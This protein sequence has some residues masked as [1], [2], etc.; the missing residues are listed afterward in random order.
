MHSHGTSPHEVDPIGVVLTFCAAHDGD[1]VLPLD[2]AVRLALECSEVRRPDAQ[3]VTAVAAAFLD[4]GTVSSHDPS[5]N[6]VTIIPAIFRGFS[7]PVRPTAEEIR[8]GCLVVGDRLAPYVAPSVTIDSLDLRTA[9]GDPVGRKRVEL[10]WRQ[11]APFHRLV[12][13]D[14]LGPILAAQLGGSF[15]PED[16]LDELEKD[17]DRPLPWLVLETQ[18]LYRSS[19]WA[20]GAV[21]RFA[22]EDWT[23]G[24]LRVGP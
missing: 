11:A 18:G 5:T 21:L 9:A 6:R 24:R 22:V 13:T 14:E 8:E 17:P 1:P 19:A 12:S 20:P 10:T 16:C 7:F 23:A 3:L 15:A 2:H 4:N